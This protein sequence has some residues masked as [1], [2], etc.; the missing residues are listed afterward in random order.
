MTDLCGAHSCLH[1]LGLLGILNLFFFG[2]FHWLTWIYLPELFIA[3]G[4]C[5]PLFMLHFFVLQVV[6]LFWGED[7]LL[8]CCVTEYYVIWVWNKSICLWYDIALEIPLP[9][10]YS[11]TVRPIIAS[12]WHAATVKCFK[13]NIKCCL[14]NH[15]W[16]CSDSDRKW[17]P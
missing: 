10:Y 16:E 7:A 4:P 12:H 9:S 2:P 5:G 17:R 11:Q 8:L 13:K 14:I 15:T 3:C 6:L 1:L